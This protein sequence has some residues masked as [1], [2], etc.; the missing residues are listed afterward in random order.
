MERFI[1]VL[2]ILSIF[3]NA[4]VVDYK[5]ENRHKIIITAVE[6]NG[7]TNSVIEPA[8]PEERIKQYKI[9]GGLYD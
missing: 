4:M 3:G 6:S 1:F 8:L 2:I 9:K 7:C 5:A